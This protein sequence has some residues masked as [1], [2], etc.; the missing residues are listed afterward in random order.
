MAEIELRKITDY[1]WEIPQ[2][3]GMRAP[4][5]IFA[6]EKLLEK[7]KED[8]T[9]IQ[10]CN[11]AHLP[12]VHSPVCVLPDAHQGYGFPVGGVAALDAEKGVI[13]PGA[14]GFDI[15]CGVRV[16]KTNLRY[17]D[18]KG[19]EQLLVDTLFS[20][21]PTGIGEGCYCGQ[22]LEKRDRQSCGTR[23]AMGAAPQLCRR[24]RFRAL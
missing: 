5:R 7:I 22:A 23:G 12:G 10:A 15:N 20:H 4:A 17:D 9:L 11:M 6:S 2:T 14:I 16:C 8:E 21:I 13:S 18:L 24:R 1:I 19:K 3:G